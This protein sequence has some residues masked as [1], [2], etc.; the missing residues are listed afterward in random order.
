MPIDEKPDSL[1]DWLRDVRAES[2]ATEF[3]NITPDLLAVL[4]EYEL[5]YRLNPAWTARL[6][7]AGDELI[8]TPFADLLYIEAGESLDD[9]R[10][11]LINAGPDEKLQLHLRSRSGERIEVGLI[12]ARRRHEKRTYIILRVMSDPERCESCGRV[13]YLESIALAHQHRLRAIIEYA[14]CGVVVLDKEAR[15]LW[16]NEYARRTLDHDSANALVGRNLFDLAHPDEVTLRVQVFR[17]ALERPNRPRKNGTIQLQNR[18]GQWKRV[19]IQVLSLLED[20]SINAVVIFWQ[21]VE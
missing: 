16:L 2:D 17:A 3:F 8:G 13:V 7:Y 12:A 11:V 19:E 18:W 1:T 4:D 20:E 5:I 15:I 9:I 6:G 10:R 21:D 14:L